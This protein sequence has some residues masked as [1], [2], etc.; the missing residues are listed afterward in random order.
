MYRET[1]SLILYSSL[2]QDSIL[3]KLSGIW[4]D[5]ESQRDTPASLTHRI[6][7]EVKRILDISTAYGFDRN[8]W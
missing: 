1:D 3:M 4:S 8:L 2:P 6:Y 7:T 5:W